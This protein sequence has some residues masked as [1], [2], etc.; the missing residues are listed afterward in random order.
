VS[1]GVAADECGRRDLVGA[2]DV[3]VVTDDL[4]DVMGTAEATSSD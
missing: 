2:A 3:E 4:L 1:R